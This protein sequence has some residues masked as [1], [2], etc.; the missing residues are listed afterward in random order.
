MTNNQTSIVATFEYAIYE[1]MQ[2]YCV[3]L[4]MDENGKRITCV[5]DNLPKYNKMMM[6][7]S[8]YYETSPK[9]GTSFRVQ[10]YEAVVEKNKAGIVSY[11]SSGII[12]GIGA[13]TAEKIYSKFGNE[14]LEVIEKE[15]ERLTAIRG[16]SRKTVEKIKESYAE[17]VINRE[18]VEFLLP[19]GI[20][21]KQAATV[22]KLL[23]IKSVSDIKSHPYR[24]FGIRGITI[25]CVDEIAK[26]LHVAEDDEERIKAHA[27]SVMMAAENDGSTGIEAKEFGL[28]LIRSLRSSCF[29][30]SNICDYTV[31]LIKSGLLKHLKMGEAPDT[32]TYIY[33][34][35]VYQKELEI[36]QMLHNLSV[37]KQ[38]DHGD[39]LRK[40]QD[41]P[42]T[43]NI[44]LDRMQLHAVESII[45]ES[46]LV[47]TGGPGTGKTSIIRHAA[48]FL[49][50]N[51]KDREIFFMAPSGRA[52]RRIKE[53][54]GF[55]GYTINSVFG[56]IPGE[57]WDEVDEEKCIEN[58]TI[59]C[60]ESSMI[61]VPL[62]YAMLK[63]IKASCRFVIV[64][65]ED[66]LPSVEYGAVLRDIIGSGKIP[67]IRLTQIYRQSDKSVIYLNSTKIKEGN[68]DLDCGDDFHI[69]NS[70]NG[71]GA[72]E[73]MVQA[74]I[75]YANKYGIRNVS[76]IVPRKGGAA[77]VKAMNQI[78]QEKLNPQKDGID[79]C[80]ANG[81]IFRKGDPVMHLNNDKDV[82]N[83]DTG[84]ITSIYKDP[85]NGY[86]IS[87]LY[88]DEIIKTYK[89]DNI[90]DLT[91]AYAF[92]VHKTQ[93]CE[94]AV[95]LTYLSLECG[96]KML[97]RNLPY[98][99]ITR[100]KVLTELYLTSDDAL[101]RAID[102]DDKEHRKTS[103]QH[104]MKRVFGDW[105]KY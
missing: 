6:K 91:L 24:L 32:V 12:K 74:Y 30:K 86:V 29:D 10:S 33:R 41:Q 7:L 66:Q 19:F 15:P 36:A 14:S 104:H 90:D 53:A 72:Q 76:C 64:G 11:L 4:F 21:P 82:A 2:G 51:E 62:M 68:A 26:K 97:R 98:T 13:A 73:K 52:A 5:G 101:Q 59:I 96:V 38:Q 17:S 94:N 99:A 83:G 77:G 89:A 50:E 102:N 70:E 56:L 60:D 58:A 46:V 54:T 3:F 44:V 69:I 23:H 78:L 31:R 8:G 105:I 57:S 37:Y 25:E 93:G 79:E 18:V 9:Y 47:I 1:S 27:I 100:G 22:I 87:A 40:L 43:D 71:I 20:S 63:R 80:R 55:E 84:V 85:E 34:A 103:L 39:V 16:I 75:D 45:R 81:M 49:K 48:R 92:T 28:S 42:Q 61:S 65:D 35:S 88:F 95:V 67:V